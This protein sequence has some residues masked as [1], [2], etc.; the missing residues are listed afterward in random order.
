MII[1]DSIQEALKAFDLP[2]YYGRTFADE[3]DKWNYIVF[4]RTN[5]SKSGRSNCDYNHYYQVH[6]IFEEYIPEGFEINIIKAMEKIGLRLENVPHTYN[7]T[8]KNNTDIVIEMLTITFTKS[9][10]CNA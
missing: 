9:R 1:L 10:R 5:F 8:T 4:N 7:Y 6:I 3:K 2:V